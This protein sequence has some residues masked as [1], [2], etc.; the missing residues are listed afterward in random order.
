MAK[1]LL[2]ALLA[3]VVYLV[4]KSRARPGRPAPGASQAENMVACA[5]CGLNVPRS[6]A[7]ESRGLLFCSDEHRALGPASAHR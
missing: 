7:I 4:L 1:I 6:E 2:F 5:R 3:I